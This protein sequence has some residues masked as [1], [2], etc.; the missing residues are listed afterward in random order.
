MRELNTVD[1]FCG[2]GGAS[3]GLE[4][5]L[6][7]LK[8]RHKGLAINHW[9]VAVDTMKRNHP[10][11]D[12]M[13]MKIEDAVPADLVPGGVV[14]LLWASPSCTHHSRAK[15]GKPRSNQLR[16]QPELVLTWLDQ[17]FVRRIIIE[18]VPEFVEWGPLNKDGKPIERLKGS[19]FRSWVASIEARNY[20]VEWR[21]VN[22]ADYGDATSRR[23]FFLKAVRK[24]CGKIRWPEPTHAEN[25]QPDLFGHELKKWRGVREC[26]DL[27]DTGKSIFNREKPLAENTLRRIMVGLRKYNGLDFQMDMLGAGEN[28]ETRV[29][30]TSAPLR[31]Q[32]TANRTA[33]VRPF[34]VRLNKCCD[35]ES[36]DKPLSTVTA[37]GQHH[38]LCQPL[39]VDHMKNGKA[40]PITEPL[41]TQHCKD[42][43]S[44]VTPYLI[45]EQANNAPRGIDKPLRAQTTVR[46][47]YLCTPLVLGQ[48]GGAAARPIDEPCPTIATGGAVRMI[49][50]LVLGRDACAKCRP[51]DKPMPTLTTGGAMRVITP[52]ILDMSRPGGHD[53]GHI[54]PASRP[55]QALTTCDN[56]QG[57]FP[58]LEDGRVIDIR[59]RMLKPSELAAAHSFPK[60]YVLTGN[61]G[62]QVKQIGNSVPVMTAK[63]MCEVDFKEAS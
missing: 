33:L 42:R 24:G 59:I 55:I 17:L 45:T 20:T 37:G 49:T 44:M 11:I 15:G 12:T 53:S 40:R 61:R 35:A 5:A 47:D 54:R 27:S 21:I 38:A 14:D 29:L 9:S 10:D 19:C 56:V 63:A 23:R 62:E 3:T 50:P 36:I 30:P 13:Q 16:A 7:R 48:Q 8:M 57:V 60:D 51:A 28:D 31:T 41:G 25:P 2:A 32:H 46:K 34:L 4:L 1:L 6:S 39:I 22:C 52:L 58:V 18:N 26:L 43:F